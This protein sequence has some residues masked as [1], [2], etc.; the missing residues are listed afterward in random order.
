MDKYTGQKR[1]KKQ[2]R[3]PINVRVYQTKTGEH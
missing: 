2:K 3:K 1:G